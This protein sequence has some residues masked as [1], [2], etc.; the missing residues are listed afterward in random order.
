MLDPIPPSMLLLLLLPMDPTPRTPA[1]HT[2][3][4][5][6]H[7]ECNLLE[8]IHTD[9]H[10]MKSE[11][12][13]ISLRE[14]ER[15]VYLEQHR[16]GSHRAGIRWSINMI[17]DPCKYVFR[18]MLNKHT[19]RLGIV[20]LPSTLPSLSTRGQHSYSAAWS[21]GAGWLLIPLS[22]PTPQQGLTLS[23]LTQLQSSSLLSRIPH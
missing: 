20:T 17:C 11:F 22:K 13:D 14:E 5:Q 16:L 7:T 8:T 1:I 21:L 15:A 12:G 10:P 4:T 6:G 9:I 3:A 2:A 23:S 18:L 19:E